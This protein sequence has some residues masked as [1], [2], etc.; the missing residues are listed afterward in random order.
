MVGPEARLWRAV[1]IQ[2]INDA[3]G[4]VHARTPAQ[5]RNATRIRDKA[6]RWLTGN[7]RDFRDICSMA[8]VNPEHIAVLAGGLRAKGWRVNC[9]I[10]IAATA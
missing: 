1:I 8:S 9:P 6:R 10:R 2:T 5:R 3:T 7:N 4:I